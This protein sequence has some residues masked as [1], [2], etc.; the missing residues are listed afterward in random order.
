DRDSEATVIVP[1][2]QQGPTL[3]PAAIPASA[4]TAAAAPATSSAAAGGE[5]RPSTLP[6]AA[7]LH[8]EPMTRQLGRYEVRAPLGRG[9]MASVYR[10]HDPDIGRDVAI[11][12]LHAS[13]CE[14]NDCRE[15]F[16]REVRAA[17]GLSHPNIVVVHD[18]GQIEGRP[19]MAMELL[20]GESLA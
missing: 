14:D 3:P 4:A 18:V 9:G 20:E 2:S 8:G 1:P 10:A 15:R 19:Y 17:G 12:F 7:S 16:L 5:A 6:G 11:K 13:L